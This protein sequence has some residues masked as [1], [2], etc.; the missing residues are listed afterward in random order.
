MLE[1]C[2]WTPNRILH[3]SASD[4]RKI[5][6]I[7]WPLFQ[8]GSDFRGPFLPKGFW[9]GSGRHLGGIWEASGRDL[10]DLGTLGHSSVDPK[11]HLGDIWEASG[12]DLGG[13]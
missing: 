2:A 1:L 6:G 7:V 4:Y 3:P 13:I 9:E 11:L 5:H 12:R 10:G 8:E